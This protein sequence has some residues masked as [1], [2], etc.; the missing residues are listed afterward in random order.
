[1]L[2]EK[3]KMAQVTRNKLKGTKETHQLAASHEFDL[4]TQRKGLAN[5]LRRMVAEELDSARQDLQKRRE[6]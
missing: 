1:V 6:K 3:R 4:V 2:D 5:K